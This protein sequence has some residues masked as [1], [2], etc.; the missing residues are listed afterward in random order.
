M[1]FPVLICLYPLLL[2]LQLA[3]GRSMIEA[4]AHIV[5]IAIRAGLV[6][7]TGLSPN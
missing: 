1:I 2:Q 5:V 7:P 3:A 6:V 4:A